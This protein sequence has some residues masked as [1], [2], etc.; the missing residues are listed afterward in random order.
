MSEHPGKLFI[1]KFGSVEGPDD[2]RQY[3]VFL[4]DEAGLTDEPPIELHKIFNRFEMPLPKRVS[5]SGQ[6]G[7]LVDADQ[8]IILIEKG[9]I[10]ARQRFSEAHELM[11]IL[12]DA[13]PSHIGSTP[14][15]RGNFKHQTKERLCN[16]G[17]AELIM[18][19]DSF[20]PRVKQYGV[21]YQ[22]GRLLASEYEVSI[23]ASLVHIARIGPGRHA[24]VLWKM[25]NKPTE[26]QNEI[27]TGQFSLFDNIPSRLPLKKLRV[28]YSFSGYGIPYIPNDKSVPNDSSIFAAWQEGNFNV[29]VD[30]LQLGSS[31]GVFRCENHPFQV[32]DE[33]L[34]L[35]LLHFPGDKNCEPIAI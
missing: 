9:D 2:V 18:P 19:E 24:V 8:G 11:E 13:L 1:K 35:S 25:K 5:L 33:R 29:G 32:E 10:E 4:R 7:L 22:T 14:Q 17:A 34:V 21:S 31:F 3:A 23:S 28:E 20:L 26:L 27:P 15:D 6:Q 30:R 16:E 12:F